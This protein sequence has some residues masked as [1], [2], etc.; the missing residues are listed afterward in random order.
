MDDPSLKD[1]GRTALLL[2][3]FLLGSAVHILEA[4]RGGEKLGLALSGLLF[5]TFA[6]AHAW[7]FL[8]WKRASSMFFF[9]FT[10]F[11]IF[12]YLGISTHLTTPYSYTDV[13][14]PRLGAVPLVVPLGSWTSFYFSSVIANLIGEGRP[15]ATLR[16]GWWVACMALL[17]AMVMTAWGLTLQPYMV[18]QAQAWAW[19]NP[20]AY[21]GIPFASFLA[22]TQTA[23]MVSVTWRL[24]AASLPP[25]PPDRQTRLATALPVLGYA[26][27][28]LPYV[29]IGVPSA[30]RVLAPFAMGIPVLAA[31][32]RLLQMPQPV[33]F[34]EP[35]S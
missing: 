29:F 23:F 21:F 16:T 4:A 14:G 12:D 30:T 22:S 18:I 10:A 5:A 35:E 2:I 7:F 3:L 27:L 13:L 1:R 25:P 31:L 11:W 19:K 15:V 26:L 17:T 6:L 20:G 32:G 33:S 34:P 24:I 9:S 8:G 28:G